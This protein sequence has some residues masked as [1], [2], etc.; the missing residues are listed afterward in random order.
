MHFVPANVLCG[1]NHNRRSPIRRHTRARHGWRN[2]QARR[3]CFMLY[4]MEPGKKRIPNNGLGRMNSTLSLRRWQ[5]Y[6]IAPRPLAINCSSNRTRA[7]WARSRSGRTPGYKKLHCRGIA[8]IAGIRR[9]NWE[10]RE[11][12]SGELQ[13]VAEWQVPVGDYAPYIMAV[14][15]DDLHRNRL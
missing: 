10:A 15:Y 6:T 4:L 9:A 11:G 7:N 8:H 1:G 2:G 5:Y 14:H 12:K 3:A 13:P